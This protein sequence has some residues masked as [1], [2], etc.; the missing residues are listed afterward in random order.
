MTGELT[1]LAVMGFTTDRSRSGDLGLG[2][3][4]ALVSV[5]RGVK[6][7]EGGGC[8]VGVIMALW[9]LNNT[10]AVGAAGGGWAGN[11]WEG[12]VEE[13]GMRNIMSLAAP[14]LRL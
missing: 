2:V 12:R 4:A 6:V 3:S 9:L 1:Q 8:L 11:W 14:L 5:E 10:G 13:G 7:E